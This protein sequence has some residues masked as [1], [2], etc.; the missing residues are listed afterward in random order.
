MGFAASS[1]QW[2][3][4]SYSTNATIVLVAK[5]WCVELGERGRNWLDN[6]SLDNTR[7]KKPHRGEPTKTRKSECVMILPHQLVS[8]ILCINNSTGR[9]T[10]RNPKL[11]PHPSYTEPLPNNF[12][13][14][15]LRQYGT[16]WI[17][18]EVL[19]ALLGTYVFTCLRAG[20]EVGDSPKGIFC[21]AE[22]NV[23]DGWPCIFTTYF[24]HVEAHKNVW[25]STFWFVSYCFNMLSLCFRN[26]KKL[27]R[28]LIT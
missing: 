16:S 26:R 14:K 4:Y 20:A 6:M 10:P 7:E 1:P 5:L 22:R 21:G 27:W 9:R 13:W 11:T 19:G 8:R 23:V 25:G 12:P 24:Q 2:V 17:I 15:F 28:S 18:A 3:V